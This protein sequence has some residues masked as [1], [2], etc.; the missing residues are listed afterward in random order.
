MEKILKAI[1]TTNKNI[2]DNIS[3]FKNAERGFLSQNMMAQLRNL[4]EHINMFLYIVETKKSLS[5]DYHSIKTAKKYVYNQGKWHFLRI[6]HEWLLKVVSHYTPEPENAERLMLKY[7]EYLLRLRN[8]MSQYEVNI[9]ENIEDFPINTDSFFQ[10]YY[11]K[12]AQCIETTPS[13]N[14]IDN[15][16][17]YIQTIK[18]FFINKKVFY[19]VSFIPANDHENKFDR[20]IGFTDLEVMSNFAVKFKIQERYIHA[21]DHRLPVKIIQNWMPAIRDCEIKHLGSYFSPNKRNINKTEYIRYMNFLKEQHYSLLDIVLLE[22]NEFNSVISQIT[23]N[24]TTTHISDIL[25]QCREFIK[26]KQ[27]GYNILS[28]ILHN[29]NNTIIKKQKGR[30]PCPLLSNLYLSYQAIPFEQIPFNTSLVNHN[31]SFYDVLHSI[32]TSN[33]EDEILAHIVKNNVEVNDA[34]YTPIS[35]IR[36]NFPEQDIE[37]L[38]MRYNQKLYYKHKASRKLITYRDHIT[39]QEYETTLHTVISKLQELSKKIVPDYTRE[40]EEWLNQ[41]SYKIDCDEKKSHLLTLFEKT[42]L[43]LIY[44]AAGTGKSTLINHVSHRF[45]TESKI[46]LTNT[47]PAIDNLKRKVTAPNTEFSTVAKFL[48]RSG[49]QQYDI[50]FI[51]ECSTISNIDMAAILKKTKAAFWV[52][53]GDVYQIDAIIFGNWFRVAKQLISQN[54][55]IELTK[56]YRTKNLELLKFWNEVRNIKRENSIL[57]LITKEGYSQR[58]DNS[59]FS[60]LSSDEIILCLNYGGLYGINNLNRLLQESNPAPAINWQGLQYKKGDPI[61]FNNNERFSHLLYNNLKGKILGITDT[62]NNIFFIVDVERYLSKGI[63]ASYDLKVLGHSTPSRTTVLIS[64]SK[65]KNYDEDNDNNF[66][67]IPFQVAYAISI[68]KAQGLEYDSVKLIIT[69]ATEEQISHDIFY[70]AITRARQHLHIYWTPETEKKVLQS[71]KP[72]TSTK[73]IALLVNKYPDLKEI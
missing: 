68:H 34:I 64:V 63:A 58:F 25:K 8:L 69:S 53:V 29:L 35:E 60:P 22:D 65:Y 15:E 36:K 56:P 42:S 16:R 26:T 55:I 54:A 40:T 18:P 37:N 27:A 66:S 23:Y 5:D 61:L 57:E 20:I 51:D 50:V 6:F 24:I 19:E 39:I 73:D 4:L 47:N 11:S 67:V 12:I 46:Y 2:C 41:T 13:T 48:L 3:R 7:Y 52:L 9:L 49:Q 30:S 59:V 28:Y 32:D 72:K 44:G 70:T 38:I 10:D 1:Y 21:L 14:E 43:A 71:I 17:Y 31:P 45:S 33:R 62:P